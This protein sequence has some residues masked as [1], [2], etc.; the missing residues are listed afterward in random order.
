MCRATP[1]HNLEVAR[2]IFEAYK[3]IKRVAKA[4]E[5]RLFHKFYVCILEN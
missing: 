4:N 2:Y 5:S 3:Q 1:R